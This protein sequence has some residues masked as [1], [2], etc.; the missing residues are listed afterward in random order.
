MIEPSFAALPACF[1]VV[2]GV[3]GSGKSTQAA[4]LAAWLQAA[5]RRVVLTR[6][7]GGTALGERLRETILHGTVACAPRAELLLIQAARAQHV[8]EVIAPALRDGV[9]VVSD[10]FTPSSLAYQGFGRGVPL[11]E[12]RAVNAV[13]TQGVTPDLTLIIDVPL[14]AALARIGARQDRFEGEGR[15][16]LQRVVDGY[17]TLANEPRTVTVDG[18]GAVDAV[19]AAVRRAVEDAFTM[20]GQV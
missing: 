5:G 19:Q 8:E 7:P 6:E 17:R 16:F 4:L 18:T 11:E 13:A 2:E 12:I 3:D 1:L 10:R 20:G 9:T 15:A 14:E